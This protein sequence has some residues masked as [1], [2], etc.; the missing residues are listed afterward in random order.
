MENH[1]RPASSDT[2]VGRTGRRRNDG[3]AHHV[4]RRTTLVIYRARP[5]ARTV[6]ARLFAGRPHLRFDLAGSAGDFYEQGRHT[7]TERLT[8][9]LDRFQNLTTF[10]RTFAQLQSRSIFVLTYLVYEVSPRTWS[11]TGIAHIMMTHALP[12]PGYEVIF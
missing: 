7:A 1:L 11:H 3:P 9:R 10:E 12:N 4:R 2:Q 5:E 8:I 6:D